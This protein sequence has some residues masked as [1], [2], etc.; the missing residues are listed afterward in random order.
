MG[1]SRKHHNRITM[2]LYTEI[3]INEIPTE[4]LIDYDVIGGE[5]EIDKI[6]DVHTGDAICP[7]L[8]GQTKVSDILNQCHEDYADYRARNKR[9][10][11]NY[12]ALAYRNCE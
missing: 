1:L 5:P 10:P 3:L 8:L 2:R 4:V 11:V 12:N 9:G 7:D 6:T